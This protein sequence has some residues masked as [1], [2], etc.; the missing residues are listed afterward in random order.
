VT[1][2][3]EPEV[4]QRLSEGIKRLGAADPAVLE[5]LSDTVATLPDRT[6]RRRINQLSSSQ[7][8]AQMAAALGIVAIILAAG[9][10]LVGSSAFG[11]SATNSMAT[12]TSSHPSPSPAAT[13]DLSPTQFAD[14]PRMRACEEVGSRQFS[15][16]LY[17]WELAHGRDYRKYIV[18]PVQPELASAQE[19]ALVV[20][21]T[22]GDDLKI[23]APPFVGS[24]QQPAAVVTP[25]AVFT[26]PPG[27]HTVC[28][29]LTGASQAV[30]FLNLAES[31]LVLP[32]AS[33]PVGEMASVA[34]ATNRALAAMTWDEARDSLWVVTWQTGPNGQLTRIDADG[35]TT[36]W[37]LPNGPDLQI[38]P[39]IQA[40]LEQPAMPAAWYGWDATDI[41]V[42]G[43]GEVWI[44]AGYALVRFDPT[45]GE[46]QVRVFQEPDMTKVY[47]TDGGS[48][49]S[50][51][52]EDGDGVLVARNGDQS[53]TRVNESLADA[54]T[55]TLPD[56]WT[57]IRGIAVVDNRVLAGGPAGLGSFDRTGIQMAT[58]PT[59]LTYSSLRPIA[60]DRA[61][62]LPVSIGQGTAV[63]LDVSAA[64]IGTI[65]LPM[66]AIRSHNR[67]VVATDWKDHVWYGD[68]G[69]E[70]P[71][72]V[73][74]A[75]VP[76]P[77]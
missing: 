32:P 67:L 24:S 7:A 18:V 72:Y 44:A 12:D 34:L 8:Y 20:V 56:Q 71:V 37:P 6:E 23:W 40:G 69:N 50:A 77:D 41:V 39:E 38:R 76:S 10:W 61:A 35:S 27:S 29:G 42:D 36:S 45:T 59:R 75:T 53:L 70:A 3:S 46:S 63:V 15:D 28:V 9:W 55:I 22:T 2:G 73:V 58:S 11:P 1:N 16:V 13:Q 30:P 48:W 31:N 25:A 47:L 21:F 54:G 26:P 19:P 5:R 64:Q 66:E 60:S 51:I 65:D 4:G 33:A 68:W 17:A 57:D 74:Q 43:E 62:I 49:L 14:D 52:A